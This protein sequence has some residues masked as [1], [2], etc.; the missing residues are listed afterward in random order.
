MGENFYSTDKLYLLSPQEVWGTS[1]TSENDKSN[2]TSRQL[3]YYANYQGNGYTG[4]STS[5]YEGAIKQYSG[6]NSRWWLRSATSIRSSFF[7]G[8][9]SNG[10]NSSSFANTSFGLAPAFRLAD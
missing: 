5:K 2:G 9:S 1:F 3:D 4:V 8:V 10:S 6:S 7:Y